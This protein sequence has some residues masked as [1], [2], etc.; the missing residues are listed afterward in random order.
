[1]SQLPLTG[2]L[3]FGQIEYPQPVEVAVGLPL[4]ALQLAQ[5]RVAL[6]TV[7][8]FIRK[9][10][11]DFYRIVAEEALLKEATLAPIR[12]PGGYAQL[13]PAR[14]GAPAALSEADMDA[15]MAG[16][17]AATVAREGAA[18]LAAGVGLG[19]SVAGGGTPL[20]LASA[21]AGG[22]GVHEAKAS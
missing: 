16:V 13:P 8:A 15:A 2:F 10:T 20:A 19:G 7:R 9:Q 14:G 17:G 22:A 3:S 5:L 11:S 21:L 1:M 12:R 6:R 4:L 18:A